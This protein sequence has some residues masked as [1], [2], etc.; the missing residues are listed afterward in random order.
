M[1]LQI[2][3]ADAMVALAARLFPHCKPGTTLLLEGELGAGKTTFVRGFLQA[4]GHQGKV[5]SPT[6]TLVEP[7]HIAGRDYYHFD[8]YRLNTQEELEGIG[9]RDY[10]DGRAICLV[11]W[12]DRAA[13]VLFRGDLRIKIRATASGRELELI[14]ESAVGRHLLGSFTASKNV[15]N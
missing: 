1:P 10:F 4:A 2:P 15:I 6:Y 12:P 11:E 13:G 9:L 7:Y 5:K 14:P 3:T 8:L